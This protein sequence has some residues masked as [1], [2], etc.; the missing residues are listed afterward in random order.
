MKRH[1]LKRSD[2]KV[3]KVDQ[4]WTTLLYKLPADSI[5]VGIALRAQSFPSRYVGIVKIEC[6]KKANDYQYRF[7][8]SQSISQS[9]EEHLI[10]I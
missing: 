4:I 1:N 8:L 9:E 6:R 5:F 7:I 3:S 10:Q 2:L